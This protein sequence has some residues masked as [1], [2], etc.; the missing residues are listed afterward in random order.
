MADPAPSERFR[1]LKRLFAEALERPPAERDAF[2]EETCGADAGLAAELRALLE[3]HANDGG[4]LEDI[5]AVEAKDALPPGGGTLR[6]RFGVYEILEGL[7]S[8][9]M[10][11][12]FL[13]RRAD[14][15][16]ESKVVMESPIFANRVTAP[17]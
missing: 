10:G 14:S 16:Y 9:G 6:G 7:G 4:F 17:V 8:G 12:V 1:R 2:I 3:A 15:E 11:T 13:A 5:V